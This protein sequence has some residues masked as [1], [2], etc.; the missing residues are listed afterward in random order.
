[1]FLNCSVSPS[2]SSAPMDVSAALIICLA[3]ALGRLCFF[4]F[5][6]VK[7]SFSPK[8]ATRRA[9]VS[10]FSTS[11]SSSGKCRPYHSRTLLEKMFSVLS[12]SSIVW[13][14]WITTKSLFSTAFLTRI[15][16]SS[17]ET[18]WVHWLSSVSLSANPVSTANLPRFLRSVSP[19]SEGFATSTLMLNFS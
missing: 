16:V 9:Y 10:W 17:M 5:F 8:S 19:A 13:I 2:S 7:F 12:R 4:R 18:L 3:L 11:L 1:M 15:L 6:T 14:T